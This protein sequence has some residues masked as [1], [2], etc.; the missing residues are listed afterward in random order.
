MNIRK[1]LK[2]KD[3]IQTNSYLSGESWSKII[4][5]EELSTFPVL[6]KSIKKEIDNKTIDKAVVGFDFKDNKY[7][8]KFFKYYYFI[9]L[10]EFK[11]TPIK[12]KGKIEELRDWLKNL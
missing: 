10:Q 12:Q 1:I 5:K 2:E 6:N 11:K 9:T 3:F 7:W 4:L 8:V